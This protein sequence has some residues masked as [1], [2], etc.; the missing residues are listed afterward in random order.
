ME[1][2]DADDGGDRRNFEAAIGLA[3]VFFDGLHIE[4]A[5]DLFGASDR[6]AIAGDRVKS[7]VLECVLERFALRFGALQCGIGMA[8]RIG[9]C[10][11]RQI[12]EVGY[13][14]GIDSLGCGLTPWLG[15][16]LAWCS[17]TL[18]ARPFC[19]TPN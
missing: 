16:G 5:G 4:T 3:Q 13:G 6:K 15:L 8:E 14:R 7:A 18:P 9:E 12:V 2:F 10:F 19:D 17:T 11:V 1:G